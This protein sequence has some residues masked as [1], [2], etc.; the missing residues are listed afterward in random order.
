MNASK[1][2]F[3]SSDDL[4][5]F[6]PAKTSYIRRVGGIALKDFEVQANM[7]RMNLYRLSRVQKELVSNDCGAALL[8]GS[9]NARYA[10]GT[11]YAQVYNMH[12]PFRSIFVPTTGKAIAF[13]WSGL[14]EGQL[15]A[16][17][18]ERRDA[19]IATYF[20]AGDHFESK[21]RAF[22]REVADLVRQSGGENRKIA[23]DI[24]EPVVMLALLN[25]GLEIISAERLMEHATAI[26]NEDELYCMAVTATIAETGLAEIRAHLKPGITE[27][28]LWSHLN[29]I[30]IDSGGEWF[31]Y[32]L[33]TSGGRTNPWGQEAT[34]K[35]IRAGELVG[36]DTGMIGPFGYGADISRTF[37]CEPGNPSNEQKRLFAYAVENLRANLDL[38]KA[39]VTFRELSEKSWE[40]PEE[41]RARR[42][43]VVMHG[44]GMGDEWPAIPFPDQ[45]GEEGYDGVLQENMVL[46]V[47]SCIG[48]T[49][50]TECVKLEECVVVKEDG[51][52]LLSTFPYEPQLHN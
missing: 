49:D 52:Q 2:P 47:E 15:P 12:S 26:K 34:D 4:W 18:A 44:L 51:Y 22:A 30:N 40:T 5:H 46:C 13:D 27:Q 28:Q 42:Y 31:E 50:G 14:N 9:V 17:I 7:D 16:T 32:R 39:G 33:L 23:L 45:W 35:I 21:A 19:K 8:F 36:V 29:R 20:P 41:F 24:C 48:R 3:N 10:T 11:R 38:V 37:F 6:D 43:P 1:T 25:E